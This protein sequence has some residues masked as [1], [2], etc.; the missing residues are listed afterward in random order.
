MITKPLSQWSDELP[1]IVSSGM[2]A[3]ASWTCPVCQTLFD[4][5]ALRVEDP[6]PAILLARMTFE[7]HMLARHPDQVTPEGSA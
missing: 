6:D 1:V 3:R 5:I 4:G 2:N 7:D